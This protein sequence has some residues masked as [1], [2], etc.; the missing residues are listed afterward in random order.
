MSQ[1]PT[2]E[3]DFKQKFED[4]SAQE[5][6]FAQAG[7]TVNQN[8]STN[9]F[10]LSSRK[11]SHSSD[12]SEQ[13]RD[14]VLEKMITEVA[15]W[16]HSRLHN[17]HLL[18][19]LMQERPELIPPGNQAYRG[20][21]NSTSP[22]PKRTSIIEV[23]DEEYI[24]GKLLILGEPGS[25]KT[26][27]LM[28]LAKELITRAKNDPN[29][30][31]PVLFNLSSWKPSK[32]RRVNRRDKESLRNWLL[33]KLETLYTVP[34]DLGLKWLKSQKL[35]LLLDG[36]DEQSFRIQLRCVKAINEL[37]LQGIY[38]PK[39]LIVCSRRTEYEKIPDE[40]KL[41]LN[42]AIC[43]QPL[44]KVKIQNYLIET[45][46]QDL[47]QRIQYSSELL[48]LLESPLMLHL[49]ISTPKDNQIFIDQDQSLNS[50][51]AYRRALFDNHIDNQ[52]S[53]ET[54]QQARYRLIWLARGLTEDNPTEFLIE[55]MQPSWLLDE[56]ERRMYRIGVGLII[57]LIIG[58]VGALISGS[59][60]SVLI[61]GLIGA[62][63]GGLSLIGALISGLKESSIR[64]F[65]T[66]RW[67]AKR[68]PWRN[69]NN[70]L[71]SVGLGE[72]LIFGVISN[73]GIT[74][75]KNFYQISNLVLLLK[76]RID[77]L[78][79]GLISGSM[80]AFINGLGE[81]DN[82]ENK[83]YANQG[84]RK[85]AFYAVIFAL[86][87]GIIGVLLGW[88]INFFISNQEF[89]FE[90]FLGLMG[91]LI[92]GLVPG[93]ACIEH[94]VLRLILYKNNYIPWNY[95]RFLNYATQQGLL[96]RVGGRYRFI[97]KLL[98]DHLLALELIDYRKT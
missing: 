65:E 23:F 14:W 39:H 29:E 76:S 53:A 42:M 82:V 93:V 62:L 3:P 24:A 45:K 26:A 37:F 85:S 58:L 12:R 80:S 36:L 63:I 98:Q 49:L 83:V 11:R 52:F 67:S 35:L 32:Y 51:Q 7:K 90:K 78:I 97:H 92:G 77:V 50:T 95:A 43:L 5:S 57:G 47:W 75:S 27:T 88:F 81:S 33:A 19:L 87:F 40:L 15:N 66:L 8:Q 60:S 28:Q 48:E 71:I 13:E 21:R 94:F 34:R 10:Y 84:I 89:Y 4:S 73:L 9:N 86:V 61:G 55:E 16:H 56:N 1:Q 79:G 69:L 72:G 20:G 46:Y 6:Q 17:K 38:E 30:P 18:N 54:R 2:D 70:G 22:Q 96:E 64:P 31:V 41:S 91:A 74:D 25:G 59:I 68:A 44:D